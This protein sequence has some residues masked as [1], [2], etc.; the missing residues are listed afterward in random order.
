LKFLLSRKDLPALLA[1][2]TQA[3][4][5]RE[6][7]LRNQSSRLD[8]VR[9]CNQQWPCTCVAPGRWQSSAEE[10]CGLNG[11]SRCEIQ[12]AVLEALTLGRAKGRNIFIVGDTSRAKSFTLKPLTLIYKAFSPPDSGSHQLADLLG[13]E[14]VWL[15]DFEYNPSFMTWPK[16]KDFLEGSPLKVAVPKTVGSNYM[17]TADAPV[18]G[19]APQR[20]KHPTAAKET[21]QMNSRIQYF[22]FTHWFDPKSC[23]EIKPCAKCCAS[24]LLTSH[25]RPNQV[26][27]I[28][29]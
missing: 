11:Y 9:Q 25:A 19:T 18:F 12:A 4:T 21:E 29:R 14:L 2:V 23:P 1:R 24:W 5:S 6:V 10:V 17:F 16:M 20:I 27:P 8:I 22:D 7:S 28:R 26:L 15:N 3:N 13:S